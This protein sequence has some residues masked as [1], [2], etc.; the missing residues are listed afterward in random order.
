MVFS[1]I[2]LFAGSMWLT[3]CIDAGIRGSGDLVTETRYPGNYYGIEMSVPGQVFAEVD[4][5]YRV[6]VQCE[7]SIIPY[8]DTEVRGGKLHLEFSKSVYDV[9]DLVV[10]VYGPNFESFAVSGSGNLRCDDLVTGSTLEAEVSGSGNLRINNLEFEHIDANISGSGEIVLKGQA[11]T[12][13][14]NVSGSGNLY[15]ENCLV[16]DADIQVSGSGDV[17]CY[18]TGH[19]HVHVSGSG[20]VG[21]KGNPSLD[22]QVSGSGSVYKIN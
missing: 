15:A 21:Y 18:V 8:F 3:S 12:I 4:S 5:V 11:Q 9:D 6:V 10:T 17:K 2:G 19:L 13:E 20:N 22:S 14:A 16:E 7:E 1:I